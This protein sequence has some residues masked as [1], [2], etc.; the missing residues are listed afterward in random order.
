MAANYL[1][2]SDVD[3][4]GGDLIDF[5]RRAASHE[6]APRLQNLEAQNAHLHQR[7]A[8]EARHR[9][10]MQ[11]EHLVPNYREIDR[12]PRWH[13]WLSE[14]DPLT[15]RVRQNVLNDAINA[16]SAA[17]VK[18][19]F[20]GFQREAD[21]A[22]PTARTAFAASADKPTYTREQIG[23]LYERHR[24]GAFS[25]KTWARIEADIFAA[26]H[27]GRVQGVYLTK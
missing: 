12:D 3:N 5:A 20:D 21:Q 14:V 10:D 26:Q 18:A 8:R 7:L 9:L 17:R 16:G 22:A 24:K 27:E 4:F 2:Q 1:T 19:L 15:G 11:V 23:Q 13:A 6:L 25:E